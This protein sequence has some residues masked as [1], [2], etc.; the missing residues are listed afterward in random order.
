M[1][2]GIRTGGWQVPHV[3][4]VAPRAE[5]SGGHVYL[6][7]GRQPFGPRR[8][9]TEPYVV[10]PKWNHCRGVVLGLSGLC[11]ARVLRVLMV[12]R[13]YRA[14][15]RIRHSARN[16]ILRVRLAQAG[17][18]HYDHIEPVVGLLSNHS[19]DPAYSPRASRPHCYMPH[20]A[21]RRWF[22]VAR[23]VLR[24]ACCVVP[25]TRSAAASSQGARTLC[26]RT[27]RALPVDCPQCKRRG[28][29]NT[30]SKSLP[31]AGIFSPGADV[32]RV[33]AQTWASPL[34][35]VP[36]PTWASRRGRVPAQM[37]GE[38]RRRRA[39]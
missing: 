32:G 28:R 13:A 11:V 7:Q 6:L 14:G 39:P 25:T 24:A 31:R 29:V 38:S 35:R 12:L 1:P 18:G 10:V 27:P 3:A 33:P 15:G 5:P 23:C 26:C 9:G 4:E 2:A 17:Y 19:I 21:C 30:C 20:A 37:W 36:A 8:R 34:G 22:R 16:S